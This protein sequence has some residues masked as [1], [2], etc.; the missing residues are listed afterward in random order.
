MP[1]TSPT[2]TPGNGE[3]EQAV[4]SDPGSF[5]ILTGDRPTGPLHI[6]HSSARSRTASGYRS[7]ASSCSS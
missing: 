7:S 4:Q 1:A 2:L 6:G 3:L 5:R